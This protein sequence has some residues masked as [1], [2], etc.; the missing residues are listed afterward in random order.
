MALTGADP[1]GDQDGDDEVGI[2]PI[3]VM[4][5]HAGDQDA[6]RPDGSRATSMYAP[7]RDAPLESL[8]S[9][10]ITTMLAARPISATTTRVSPGT[11]G[12]VPIRSN[13]S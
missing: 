12:S 1:Q 13:A 11:S 10:N 3:V 8:R 5:D 4:V 6:D 2:G 9:S 7:A